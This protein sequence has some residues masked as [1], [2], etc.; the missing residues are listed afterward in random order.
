M[1]LVVPGQ[2]RDNNGLNAMVRP[3]NSTPDSRHWI[4][5]LPEGL[6]ASSPE[7]FG[8]YT[9]EI[10][11]GH[12]E[13]RWS[14]AQ[15]RFGPSLRVAGVQ[16]PAPPLMCQAA[17]TEKLIRVR[18]PYATPV[19]KGRNVRP[20]LPKTVLWAVLY[21]RV[22][23]TDGVSWRNLVVSKTVLS[24]PQEAAGFI[25]PEA[26]NAA[27]IFGEGAFE[28]A[29]VRELLRRVGLPET[30]PLTALAVELFGSSAP[31]NP[32]PDPLGADLGFAHILRISSLVTVSDAC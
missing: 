4:V 29:S 3:A 10:R 20:L 22:R 26:A 15:G 23:Q 19:Y 31:Q 13:S 25:L 1:R 9:Y 27:V 21:A 16:H 28:F 24:H 17:R 2:P 30:A 11:L 14:T 5:P 8:L 12:T 7:L 18:A 32:A 6:I